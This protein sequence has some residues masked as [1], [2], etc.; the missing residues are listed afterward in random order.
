M[1]RERVGGMT[2]EGQRAQEPSATSPLTSP[3]TLIPRAQSSCSQK[4]GQLCSAELHYLYQINLREPVWP[5]N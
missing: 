1:G 4:R 5:P 3:Q 2:E